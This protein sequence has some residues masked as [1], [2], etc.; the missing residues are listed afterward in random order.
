[1]RVVVLAWCT[2]GCMNE[3]LRVL[4]TVAVVVLLIW[5]VVYVVGALA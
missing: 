2:M 5:L 4:L 1:V 3:I